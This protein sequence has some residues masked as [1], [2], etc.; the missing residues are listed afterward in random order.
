M[1][2]NSS[3]FENEIYRPFDSETDSYSID[4]DPDVHF[5]SAFNDFNFCEYYSVERFNDFSGAIPSNAF[6]SFHLN[7]RSLSKNYDEFVHFLHT[8]KHTFTVIALS[9]T[10]LSEDTKDFFKLTNYQSCH[11]VRQ[12]R[13]GGGVSLFIHNDFEFQLRNDLILNS[14]NREIESLFVELAGTSGGKN[15]IIGVIY[16]PPDSCIRHFIESLSTTLDLIN[17]ENKLC[18]LL[19]DF[20]INILKSKNNAQTNE[21]IN[22]L[23][24]NYFIPLIHKPTRVK[25]KSFS[26]IDNIFY[27]QSKQ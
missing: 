21:F 24:S 8:L 26:L 5:Y 18:F 1:S 3:V 2:S 16:R 17:Y 15:V 11:Y 14:E 13:P 7:I 23:F 22:I 10:W 20:N 19:G 4:I 25:D 12:A 6:S 9:E 27:K